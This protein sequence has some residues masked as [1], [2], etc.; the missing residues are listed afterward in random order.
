MTDSHRRIATLARHEYRA[1]V[2]SRVLLALLAITLVTTTASIYIAA[3]DYRGQLADYQAYVQAAYANGIQQVAPSPLRLLSLLRGT[4][5]Y[6]EIIGAVIGITLGYLTVARERS[7]GTT[8]LLRS[9]PVTSGELAAG[10]ALGALG[11]IATYLAATA[12][13]AIISLG[14]VGNDWVGSTD[15]AKLALVFLAA[16]AYL[17]AFYL[18]GV[19]FTAHAKVAI[20][21]L[22]VA[23]ALWLAIVLILP[24]IGDTLDPDN[25][26]PGGL[27]AALTVT[28]PQEEQILSHFGTYETIRTNIEVASLEK[29][30]ERF[31]FAMTDVKD[32]YAGYSIG[33]LFVATYGDVIWLLAS[34]VL[35]GVL[36]LR[37]FRRRPSLNQGTNP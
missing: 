8:P 10:S 24:Q 11:L 13:I 12:A 9:R 20:N 36:Y 25:Q 26:L 34:P 33:E 7:S 29:H 30:F 18:I 35:I 32:K 19:I 17:T 31:A 16:A 28:K 1:A 2:R 21:G 3:V 22:M 14:V 4:L 6:L 37:S 15:I 27:F 23:L 5:E